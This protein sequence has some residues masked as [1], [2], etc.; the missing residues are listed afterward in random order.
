[1]KLK[2]LQDVLFATRIP[3]E[4]FTN[5]LR[6]GECDSEQETFEARLQLADFVTMQ[7]DLKEHIFALEQILAIC[8]AVAQGRYLE[9]CQRC[10]W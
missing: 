5:R 4:L 1:M 3:I 6:W 2:E 7:A 8:T 9:D 10:H